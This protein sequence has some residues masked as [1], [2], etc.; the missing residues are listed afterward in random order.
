MGPCTAKFVCLHCIEILGW[1][2]LAPAV[3]WVCKQS[4]LHAVAELADSSGGLDETIN[5]YRRLLLS[6]GHTQTWKISVYL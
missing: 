4:A 5:Q 2:E 1:A 3:V 6:V